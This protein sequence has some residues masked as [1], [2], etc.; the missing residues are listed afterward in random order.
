MNASNSLSKADLLARTLTMLSETVERYDL[1][2]DQM[3]V[4]NNPEAATLFRWL[5]EKQGSRTQVVKKLSEGLTLPHISP[6]DYD[7]DDAINTEVP[8]HSSAHYMMTPY[9]TLSLAIDV[10]QSAARL[11]SEIEQTAQTDE[12]KKLAHGFAREASEFRDYLEHKRSEHPLPEKDWDED[13][14]PPQLLE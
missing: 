14:D 1:F 10:E 11:F 4:V 2:A 5:S 8:G 3:D 7:W 13:Y 9:H 12:T 6:W